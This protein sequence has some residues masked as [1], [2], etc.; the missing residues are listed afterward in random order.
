M[1]FVLSVVVERGETTL[2][3]VRGAFERTLAFHASKE[4]ISFDRS[5]EDDLMEDI[6]AYQRVLAAKGAVRLADHHLSADGVHAYVTSG[7]H[8]YE[9]TF[10][11]LGLTCECPAASKFY[12][13]QI[14]KHQACAIHDLLFEDGVDE[15]ARAR[16]IY[17]CGYVFGDKLTIGTRISLALELLTRWK[18]VE[19]IADGWRATPMGDVAVPTG[20]D[21][22]LVHQVAERIGA[23]SS[24]T[25]R[26]IAG[27]AV[28]DYFA[29]EKDRDRW[30]A[31][32]DAWIR[33]VDEHSITLP[34]KYRGDFERGLEDLARVCL[35]YEKSAAALDRP[36]IAEQARAAAGAIR[37]GVAPEL[38]P[39]MALQLPQ[40]GRARTRYLHERGIANLADLAGADPKRLAD[41]RRAPEIYVREWI[42]RAKEI[43]NARAVAAADR[44]EADQEFDE[45]VARF[46]L[47]PAALT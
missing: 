19:R 12:R 46:R 40:L 32:V 18:L 43:H 2:A 38:V 11:V 13:G 36:E 47:D 22:L 30:A 6:P 9:V 42:E 1:R 4:P 8:G 16:T 3:D 5:F 41:P 34:T 25:Y 20:F 44:E 21:L 31:A 15:E 45:L 27:W 37:Y 24:A 14:C 35:L 39:L 33:E 17:N 7:D 10:G 29:N 28:Q 23:G 26:E